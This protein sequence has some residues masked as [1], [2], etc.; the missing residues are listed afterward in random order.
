MKRVVHAFFI[1]HGNDQSIGFNHDLWITRFHR[2]HELMIVVALSDPDE[3]E[4]GFG[5][6][7]W[8]IAK[9]FMIRSK[10]N[11][12]WCLCASNDRVPCNE[13]QGGKIR[14]EVVRAPLR[15]ESRCIPGPETS[16]GRHSFPGSTF[17]GVFNRFHS[18]GGHSV[19]PPLRGLRLLP[20]ELAW[21]SGR[22]IRQVETLGAVMRTISQPASA[23]SRV[24]FTVASKSSVLVVVI[25]WMRTG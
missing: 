14:N 1:H 25:D 3:F 5:H 20:H 22:A 21:Q 2:E 10:E 23:K 13:E 24:C 17:L 19:Y 9:R 7:S 16:Y 15:I 4:S 6:T 18:G 8:R 12:D 11:H